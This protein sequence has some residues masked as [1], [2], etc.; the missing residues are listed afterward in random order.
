MCNNYFE[1]HVDTDD[2]DTVLNITDNNDS[3]MLSLRDW[4]RRAKQYFFENKGTAI[5]EVVTG[6]GKTMIAINIIEELLSLNPKMKILIVVPKNVILETGWYKELVDYGIPIQNIGVYYG[7][8]KEYAQ[9]TLTNV[10]S[11]KRVPLELFDMIVADECHNMGTEKLLQIIKFPFKYK[12]GL[13][14]TLKRLDN[15][16]YDIMKLFNYNI[17]QY[18][19]SEAL[20]DGIL[21]PFK[22]I[23][24]GT[25]LDE[26]SRQIYDD[27]TQQLNSLFASYGSYEKMMRTSSPIKFKMLALINERKNLVNNYPEKFIIGRDIIVKHRN[28]KI[29]VFNQ[30]NNQTSKM[31]WHLLEDNIDCRVLHSGIPKANRDKILSDF[32]ND[33]F[34]VLL[35]TKVLDEGYNI[36]KLDVAIIMA[37]DSTDKQT[38]QRMGRV[39]RKKKNKTSMLYQIYC[40]DTIEEN[41]ADTRAKLFKRLASDYNDLQHLPGT[42]LSL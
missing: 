4:Q 28:D 20:N 2:F 11:V 12:L 9:I 25:P 7:D 31:Y 33:K 3:D 10:Q 14:A 35:T 34:N 22:F 1:Q 23:N 42:H 24:V 39:L 27:V 36:P 16:H 13:T 5:F 32:K 38:I 6:A 41:N 37:G 30:F 29:I 8:V 19:P 15:K 17:F 40:N 21:N 26:K 18:T